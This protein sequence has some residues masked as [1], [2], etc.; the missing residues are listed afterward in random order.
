MPNIAVLTS[1]AVCP[2]MNAAVMAAVRTASW[3]GMPLIGVRNGF[4][5]LLRSYENNGD[6]VFRFRRDTVLDI[7][8]LP[9]TYLGTA[10][11]KGLNPEALECVARTLYDFDVKGLV[12]IGGESSL[13][14]AWR[15]CEMGIPC[16]GVPAAIDN[17]FAYTEMSLGFDTAVNV[18][19]DAVRAT[20]SLGRPR[21]VEVMGQHCGDIALATAAATG[22]EIVLVPE[23]KWDVDS[24]AARLKDQ[25]EQ[26]NDRAAV[27]AAEGCWYAM[28]PFD[29]EE[30]QK[31]CGMEVHPYELMTA[32]RFASVLR[33]K[34]GRID[35]R[36][37][38]VGDAQRGASPTARDS[39]FAFEAGAMSVR[40]LH[41]GIGGQAIGV[42]NGSVFHMP[43]D[44][45]L[46]AQ[47]RFDRELYQ[48]M[49]AQ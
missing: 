49:N 15:L 9:G 2:G 1:G 24:V 40:L 21:V 38:V 42:K 25:I 43:I 8:G 31:S 4:Q 48:L 37:T 32:S 23:E 27:V 47:K 36:H 28:K 12:V 20:R 10:P 17:R 45:A 30:F 11:C 35:V 33:Y 46:A 34:C 44:Q 19:V 5:G 3:L 41:Q 26:G 16:V 7:A 14:E 29:E 6:T 22:S 18:C 39:S 13:R